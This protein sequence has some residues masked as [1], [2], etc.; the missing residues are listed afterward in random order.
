MIKAT[1][2]L[3]GAAAIYPHFYKTSLRKCHVTTQR[4]LAKMFE[5]QIDPK[6]PLNLISGRARFREIAKSLVSR[7]GE[8]F[9]KLEIPYEHFA[10]MEKDPY[11]PFGYTTETSVESIYVND[12]SK[13]NM[14]RMLKLSRLY[15][16]Y[17]RQFP[18]RIAGG[19]VQTTAALLVARYFSK[20]LHGSPVT[21][22]DALQLCERRQDEN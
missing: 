19:A 12:G 10:R 13:N 1:F 3:T 6:N 11:V 8:G 22:S 7:G 9:V 15:P 2:L 20:R 17:A 16:S 4:L 18:K 21:I 5:K 14:A